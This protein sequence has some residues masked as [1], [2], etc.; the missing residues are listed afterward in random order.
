MVEI[1]TFRPNRGLGVIAKAEKSGLGGR[2]MNLRYL[3]GGPPASSR[4][5]ARRLISF[6]AGR[7]QL[8]V[9]VK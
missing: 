9:L 8:A 7:H 5:S 1:A 6:G 2:V 4:F 3:V